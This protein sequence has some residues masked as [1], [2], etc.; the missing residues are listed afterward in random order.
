M[1]PIW[2]RENLSYRLSF[3]PEAALVIAQAASD[4]GV[5]LNLA[6]CKSY[7][8]GLMRRNVS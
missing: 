2:L 8:Y 1:L 7:L 5:V 4:G 6:D 3:Q